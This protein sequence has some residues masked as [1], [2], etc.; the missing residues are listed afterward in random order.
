MSAP[1]VTLEDAIVMD[2]AEDS[3]RRDGGMWID[4]FETALQ[5]VAIRK[6]PLWNQGLIEAF[7]VLRID[8][9]APH[10]ARLGPSVEPNGEAF[11]E[12]LVDRLRQREPAIFLPGS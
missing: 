7:W 2:A 8:S 5:R 11:F 1:N 9:R 12:T 4:W 10:G 3:Q 6:A